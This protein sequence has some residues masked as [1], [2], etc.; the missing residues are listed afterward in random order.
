MADTGWLKPAA[1]EISTSPP[2]GEGGNPWYYTEWLALWQNFGASSWCASNDSRFPPVTDTIAWNWVVPVGAYPNNAI[3]TG[4]EYRI[5]AYQYQAGVTPPNVSLN[6][7]NMLSGQRTIIDEAPGNPATTPYLVEDPND[8][9]GGSTGPLRT[10]PPTHNVV[11]GG[12]GQLFGLATDKLVSEFFTHASLVNPDGAFHT[13]LNYRGGEEYPY[14]EASIY[15]QYVEMK[16]H[17]DIPTT[18]IDLEADPT[19][20]FTIESPIELVPVLGLEAGPLVSFSME[21]VLG[22]ITNLEA[23]PEIVF[24]TPNDISEG[25][26]YIDS[27]AF[28]LLEITL[29]DTGF[30][31]IKHIDIEAEL[32]LEFSMVAY[33]AGTRTD[34]AA[35]PGFTLSLFHEFEHILNLAVNQDVDW[36]HLTMPSPALVLRYDLGAV[37]FMV[38]SMQP[39]ALEGDINFMA[40]C[41]DTLDGMCIEF[42]IEA[43]IG[44]SRHLE[45]NPTL[46]FTLGGVDN[47]SR[48]QEQLAQPVI[49]FS[50]PRADLRSR[51]GEPAPD[52]RTIFM[53]P[54]DRSIA[55]C[56]KD[57]SLL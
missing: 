11:V 43:D 35:A 7:V 54:V 52:E 53:C 49:V 18:D 46:F 37:P 33:G 39:P 30:E 40:D 42:S 48:L 36:L 1:S 32:L 13:L 15:L 4:L 50:I 22:G 9:P 17:Y 31:L 24:S 27:T 10:D 19:K 57:T 51:Y 29:D 41:D 14:V 44:Y 5:W 55:L 47:L 12:P 38:L 56:R 6:P 20:A 26:T 25:T 16:I 28:P 23:A 2:P 34:M 45:S 8:L 3:I 21:A